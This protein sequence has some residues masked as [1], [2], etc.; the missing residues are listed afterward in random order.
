VRPVWQAE[1]MSVHVE[2]VE[3][4]PRPDRVPVLI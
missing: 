1:E 4:V 2:I 3:I